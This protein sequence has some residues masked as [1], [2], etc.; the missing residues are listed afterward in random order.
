[1]LGATVKRAEASI[2]IDLE[3]NAFLYRMVRRI[4][5]TLLLV[6]KHEMSVE[7]F[8]QVVAKERRAGEAAPAHG[9][10]LLAV[11]YD[12]VTGSS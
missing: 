4:V 3:A 7:E 5:G 9:L 6:G 10:C 12:L 2:W 1:M 8:S 11:K